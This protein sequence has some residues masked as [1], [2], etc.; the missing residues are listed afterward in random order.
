MASTK[1]EAM[2]KTKFDSRKF[3][4]GKPRVYVPVAGAANVSRLYVW[5]V[6][7]AEYRE[8]ESGKP[9]LARRWDLDAMGAKKRQTMY[10]ETLAEARAWQGHVA[11]RGT[12]PAKAQEANGVQATESENGGPTFSQIVED[13]KR[14]RYPA[15]AVSTQNSYNVLLR[16]HFGSLMGMILYSIT[17]VAVDEWIKDMVANRNRY[18]KAAQRRSF[19]HELTLLKTILGYYGENR[20]DLRFVMPVKKRHA[21]LVK[22]R[23]RIKP[24]VKDIREDELHRFLVELGR[25][26]E[27]PTMVGLATLQFY[28]ALRISEAAALDWEDVRLDRES[29]RESR[30][31]FRRHLMWIRGSREKS[32]VEWGFK[33]SDALGGIKEHPM[34][35]PVFDALA[36]L[37]RPGAVGL[38]FRPADGAEFFTYR[39]VQY[40]YNKALERAKLP[41]R[42][43]HI[44]RHGGS[45]KTYND[46]RGDIEIAKQQ[47]G[48]SDLKNVLR[49]ARRSAS[50]FTDHVQGE[51]NK[52]E[53]ADAGHKWSQKGAALK[54]VEE[55]Q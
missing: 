23:N 39:Q 17:P 34:L 18:G 43:T 28:Q 15:L 16:L 12:N 30:I 29:P 51:W 41:Y 5:N 40:R 19:D 21:E 10:F 20:D 36:R 47:L 22:V 46:T 7:K 35:P 27:G 42:S 13:W 8:P 25:G 4:E 26:V 45:S 52:A 44:M 1:E 31:F 49:Y 48:N 11:G 54:L 3:Q 14:A 50:A 24:V 53:A 38:I 6:K 2:T 33:N 37:Y 55:E 32:F 9:Y